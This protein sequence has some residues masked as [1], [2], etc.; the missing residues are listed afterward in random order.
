MNHAW[1]S[2]KNKRFSSKIV[3]IFWYFG[4]DLT[5]QTYSLFKSNPEAIMEKLLQD[6]LGDF[7]LEQFLSKFPSRNMT[8]FGKDFLIFVWWDDKFYDFAMEFAQLY[9]KL[10]WFLAWVD[11]VGSLCYYVPFLASLTT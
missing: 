1:S 3:K 5:K 9:C 4:T 2:R 11:A 6:F 7:F 10:S 8:E